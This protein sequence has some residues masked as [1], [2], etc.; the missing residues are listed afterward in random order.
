MPQ[1]LQVKLLRVLQEQEINR[2]GGRNSIKIDVRIVAATNQN[3]F[4]KVKEKLFREDLYYRLNVVPITLVPLRERS[5]DIPDLIKYFLNKFCKE[6]NIN[7]NISPKCVTE[8]KKYSWHGNVRE[9]ENS[10]KRALILSKDSHL[11]LDDFP[12]T[13]QKKESQVKEHSLESLAYIKLKDA[14]CDIEKIDKGELYQLVIGQVERAL[15]KLIMEKT[16]CNQV[17]TS[18]IL[19]I[20]RNTLRKKIQELSIDVS[21]N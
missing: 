4:E 6:M 10:I 14:F 11:T 8:L 19:G 18:D 15:I 3:L 12:S 2:V 9:L 16:N 21:K 17:R 13:E 7:K 5:E 1:E 20:N